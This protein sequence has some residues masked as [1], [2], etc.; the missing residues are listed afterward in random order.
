MEKFYAIV[1]C[2]LRAVA[3]EKVSLGLLLRSDKKVIFKYS[4][5]KLK[6][7][8]D[9][10]PEPAF[11]LLKAQLRN[12]EEYF[13]SYRDGNPL[14]LPTD[15]LFGT[16][17]LNDVE[18][19]KFVNSSYINYLNNY[20]T[21]LLT[22]SKPFALTL[23][24]VTENSFNNLYHKLIYYS[25]EI[26]EHDITIYEKV[27]SKVN[28]KIKPYVNLDIELTSENL[29]NLVIPTTVWFIGQ[30]EVDVTGEIFD[31][32]KRTYFL[33][34]DISKYLNLIHTLKNDPKSKKLG[35]HFLVGKEPPKK[36]HSNHTLWKNV[37]ELKLLEFVS[38]G[39]L[40]IINKYMVSHKVAPLIPVAD[41]DNDSDEDNPF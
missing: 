22:F 40:D 33:E 35:T 24:A 21:N 18:L 16:D 19:P 12:M 26:I 39:E 36:L 29:K 38:L 5:D 32:N 1:Y 9:L 30:N 10:L 15:S 23:D 31:F 8:R 3:D 20:S 6:L 13:I 11:Q 28:R 14:N 41:I 25:D 37:R 34:N 7:I 17:F 27:K 2:Q 4:H